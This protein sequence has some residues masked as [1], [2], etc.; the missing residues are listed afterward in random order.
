MPYFS[1]GRH[2]AIAKGES[3]VRLQDLLRYIAT[4]KMFHF[5]NLSSLCEVRVINWT[6]EKNRHE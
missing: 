2:V 4:C 5:A 1:V 6:K 3:N